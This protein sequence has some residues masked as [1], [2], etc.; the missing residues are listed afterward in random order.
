VYYPAGLCLS[1]RKMIEAMGTFYVVVEV[2][3]L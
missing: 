3:V 1:M 2:A